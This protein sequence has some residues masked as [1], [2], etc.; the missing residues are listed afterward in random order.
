MRIIRGERIPSINP[1]YLGEWR[2]QQIEE[3]CAA[4]VAIDQVSDHAR[5]HDDADGQLGRVNGVGDDILRLVVERQSERQ[6]ARIEPAQV[7]DIEPIP[8]SML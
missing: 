2:K 6:R 4:A 1:K 3:S 7:G 5:Q 8:A